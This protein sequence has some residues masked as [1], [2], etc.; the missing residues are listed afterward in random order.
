VIG[1]PG[2]FA[3][4][5]KDFETFGEAILKKL[6]AEIADVPPPGLQASAPAASASAR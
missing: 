1:G 3:I 4:A 2:A 5:A 6:I